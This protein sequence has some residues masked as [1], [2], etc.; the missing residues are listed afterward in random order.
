MLK[1]SICLKGG[2]H[3]KPTKSPSSD[4][5]GDCGQ[6]HCSIGDS[7]RR[8]GPAAKNDTS[9]DGDVKVI[10]ELREKVDSAFKAGDFT[11]TSNTVEPARVLS[12][13]PPSKQEPEG[14]KLQKAA[15]PPIPKQQQELPEAPKMY[16]PPP[17]KQKQEIPKPKAKK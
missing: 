14:K 10:N 16:Q 5:Y 13:S 9:A 15:Q 3:E 17:P 11:K 4:R 2:P 12:Q 1:K 6:C 7:G 8:V